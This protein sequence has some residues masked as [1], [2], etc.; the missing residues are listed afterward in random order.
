MD[1][2]LTRLATSDNGSYLVQTELANNALSVVEPVGIAH[3]N[4]IVDARC[5]LEDAYSPRN[6]RLAMYAKEL[7][8][9]VLRMHS[10]PDTAGE[11]Y[12]GH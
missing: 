4:D 5:L 11:Y 12:G 1:G 6:Y 3:N 10:R 7:L 8:R 2:E 9:K